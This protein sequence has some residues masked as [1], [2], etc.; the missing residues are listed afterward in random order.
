VKKFKALVSF[1]LIAL[2][3]ACGGGGGGGADPYTPVP[4]PS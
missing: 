2:I 3:T 4:P 1:S